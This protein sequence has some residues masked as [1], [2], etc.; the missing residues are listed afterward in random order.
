MNETLN[1]Q[2]IGDPHQSKISPNDPRLKLNKVR[3]R[4]LKKGPIIGVM[5]AVL[6]VVL[7]ALT[8][9]LLPNSA[10]NNLQ[11]KKESISRQFVIPESIRNSPT[12]IEEPI[13]EVL[14][15][16]PYL[17]P[18]IPRDLSELTVQLPPQPQTTS[19][20]AVYSEQP[21]IEQQREEQL[22]LKAMEAGPFFAGG[23]TVDEYEEIDPTS[24]FKQVLSQMQGAE[25]L[26]GLLGGQSAPAQA[27]SDG[28]ARQNMQGD[29]KSFLSGAGQRDSDY[30]KSQLSTPVSPYEVKAGSIIP[31]TLITGINSDLPGEIIGQVRE[32]VYDTVSGN[33]L[34]IPQGSRLMAAYDSS[35]AFGQE[36]ILLCWNRLIRPDGSSITLECSPGIDL[37]GYAGVS[38]E[39]DNHWWRLATG[40]IFSSVLAATASTSQGDISG[41]NATFDQVFVGNIGEEINNVGQQITQKNLNIQPTIKV[42]P[43]YSVNV[44][45][46]KDVILAPY[47]R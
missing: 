27:F 19:F 22:E 21:S 29:K 46:N 35:I 4:T 43:G 33:H 7:I 34:L 2:E 6:G 24:N 36:R 42:R 41:E 40:V 25:S 45:V 38:D 44:L 5:V 23:S 17:G 32:N 9:A 47:N 30:L 37:S 1:N 8:F 20:P 13:E 10:Q 26:N 11:E 28:V 39:V 12:V 31:L 3:G 18:P 14:Q 15:S 16:S